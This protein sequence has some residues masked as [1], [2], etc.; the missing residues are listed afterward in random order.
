MPPSIQEYFVTA[1][2]EQSLYLLTRIGSLA[3]IAASC[4]GLML[5][6]KKLVWQ[7]AYSVAGF[8]YCVQGEYFRPNYFF[9]WFLFILSEAQ[10]FRY[11]RKAFLFINGIGSVLLAV[12]ISQQLPKNQIRLQDAHLAT[13]YT[14]MIGLSLAVAYLVM[15]QINRARAEKDQAQSRFLLVGKQAVN[16]IHDLKSLASAPQLYLDLL[17]EQKDKLNPETEKILNSLKNDLSHMTLKTRELYQMVQN[18][19]FESRQESLETAVERALS[20]L[21]TRLKKVEIQKTG[22]SKTIIQSG[23]FELIILNL[24]YNSLEA[25]ARSE[26][27]SPILKITLIE[28]SLI[29]EDNAGGAPEHILREFTSGNLERRKGLGLYLIWDAGLAAN[30]DIQLSNHNLGLRAEINV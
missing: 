24:L 3:L 6:P 22:N 2:D 13:D 29:I 9:A 25:W 18:N 28:N 4:L 16:I 23:P 19:S 10:F 14:M 15:S 8:F 12:W 17:M 27:E 21:A 20:F 26:T 7:Y 1:P 5:Q 11:S 30:Y